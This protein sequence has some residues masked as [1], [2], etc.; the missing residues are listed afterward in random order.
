M[1]KN[2]L[3]IIL[4]RIFVGCSI[5]AGHKYDVTGVDRIGVGQTTESDVVSMM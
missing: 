4:A 5:S 3:V 1:G 2:V